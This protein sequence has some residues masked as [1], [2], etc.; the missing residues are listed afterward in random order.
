M[1]QQF[2]EAKPHQLSFFLVEDE[3]LILLMVTEMLEEMGHTVVA[4]A[5]NIKLALSLAQTANFDVAILDVNL[6]G[7]QIEPV[8]EAISRRNLP[9][10]IASGYVSAAAEQRFRGR[11]T[12]QKPFNS[13]ELTKVLQAF[14]AST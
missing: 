2:I 8:A 5:N 11:P 7:E 9:F 14:Q 4:E 13:A 3:A 10:I 6:G 12:L 1:Q